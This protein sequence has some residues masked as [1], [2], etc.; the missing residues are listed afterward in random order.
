MRTL[1]P[2]LWWYVGL[3]GLALLPL[4]LMVQARRDRRQGPQFSDVQELKTWAEGRGLYCRSDWEDGRV[5]D[6]LAVSTHPLTWEQV[7]RLCRSRPGKGADWDG[8]LWAMAPPSDRDATPVL[9]WAGE[10][11]VWGKIFVTGDPALLDR[12]ESETK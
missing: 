11:R 2:R 8:V 1:K 10:C 4:L 12:L 3:A 7:G 9:P 6:G 5:T